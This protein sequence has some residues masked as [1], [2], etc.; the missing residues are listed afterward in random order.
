MAVMD[1]HA[2]RMYIPLGTTAW[3]KSG[4][5]AG[6]PSLRTAELLPGTGNSERPTASQRKSRP[7]PTGTVTPQGHIRIAGNAGHPCLHS[8]TGTS[9]TPCRPSGKSLLRDH[10]VRAWDGLA[11]AHPF[12]LPGDDMSSVRRS[13]RK[14]IVPWAQARHTAVI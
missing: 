10:P 11:D 8:T 3:L 5:S 2:W 12:R 14:V 4:N 6:K 13:G 9:R 7:S 1:A